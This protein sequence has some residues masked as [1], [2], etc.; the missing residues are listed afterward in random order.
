MAPSDYLVDTWS[1]PGRVIVAPGAV[2]PTNVRPQL[3][4]KIRWVSGGSSRISERAKHAMRLLLAHWA[5]NREAVTSGTARYSPEVFPMGYDALIG[6]RVV[7][8]G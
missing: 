7:S 3:G 1:V 2:W 5:E 4:G 6:D 8:F